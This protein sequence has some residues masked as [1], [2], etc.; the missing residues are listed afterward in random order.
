[1]YRKNIVYK[2]SWLSTVL[3]PTGGLE[4]YP[5]GKERLI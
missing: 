3:G 5:S 4:T 2:V 1:M